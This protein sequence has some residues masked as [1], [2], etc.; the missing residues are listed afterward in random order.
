MAPDTV[1]EQQWAGEEEPVEEE[2]EE[3]VEA[4]SASLL[5][6]VCPGS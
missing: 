2:V 5:L 1:A 3:A 4:G 6:T